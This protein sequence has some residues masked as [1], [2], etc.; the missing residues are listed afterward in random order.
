M[1][2]RADGVSACCSAQSLPLFSF[3]SFSF[4]FCRLTFSHTFLMSSLTPSPQ[5]RRR[6]LRSPA[7]RSPSPCLRAR[8]VTTAPFATRTRW[9]PSST[10]VDTCVSATPVA[11]NSR[12]CLTLVVPFAGE[13]S[14]TSLRSTGMYESVTKHGCS[15]WQSLIG[16]ICHQI[17]GE[18]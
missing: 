4:C 1:I 12:K 13:Q 18:F 17:A 14:E 6:P 9:T 7:S 8:G 2:P 11:S 16:C 5:R 10:P 3:D 15:Q